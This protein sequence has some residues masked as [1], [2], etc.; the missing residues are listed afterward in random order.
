LYPRVNYTRML[1]RYFRNAERRRLQAIV[2]PAMARRSLSAF[3]SALDIQDRVNDYTLFQGTLVRRH[4]QVFRGATSKVAAVFGALVDLVRTG[5]VVAGAFALLAYLHQQHQVAADRWLG[6][7]L[8]RVMERVPP[9]DPELWI[10]VLVAYTYLVVLLL[11]LRRRLRERDA[12][13]HD[14]VAAV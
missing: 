9:L 6:P 8:A 2:S 1:Q 4:A 7:Q 10:V 14:R 11:R 3:A 5:T 12:R 13:S